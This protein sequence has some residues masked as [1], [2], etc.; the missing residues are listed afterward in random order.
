MRCMLRLISFSLKIYMRLHT[1]RLRYQAKNKCGWWF[2]M[3]K[4]LA[5]KFESLDRICQPIGT[6]T[7]KT[8]AR[9]SGQLSEPQLE[10]RDN[11]SHIHDAY[12]HSN[13]AALCG[14]LLHYFNAIPVL[15]ANVRRRWTAATTTSK[16][17]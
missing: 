8:L 14:P 9:R 6:E 12:L 17:S 1:L 15:R 3:S 16:R 4:T 5:K 7:A 13:P 2:A 10:G 11:T